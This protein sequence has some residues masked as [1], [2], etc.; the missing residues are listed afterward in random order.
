[1]K[2]FCLQNRFWFFPLTMV[3]LLFFSCKS[4]KPTTTEGT[5]KETFAEAPVNL[6]FSYLS[7]KVTVEY[8]GYNLQGQIRIKND[9]ILWLSLS[10]FGLELGRVKATPDSVF[11]LNKFQSECLL[12]S[13][14]DLSKMIGFDINFNILQSLLLGNDFAC[15]D[16]QALKKQT[17]NKLWLFQFENRKTLDNCKFLFKNTLQQMMLVD[18]ANKKII[19]N[20][21]KVSGKAAELHALYSNFTIVGNQLMSSLLKLSTGMNGNA[22]SISIEYSGIQFENSLSFPFSIPSKYKTGS[23]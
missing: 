21:L 8:D 20:H 4:T 7:S 16:N 11:F 14:S 13:Y 2:F 15:F 6:D 5:I 22:I 12:G 19:E 10:K 1:M 9:S 18:P 23:F 3:L 17:D